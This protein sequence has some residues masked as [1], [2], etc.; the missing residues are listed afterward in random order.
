MILV[1]SG[2]YFVYDLLACIYYGLYDNALLAH[3]L[4]V[5][6]LAEFYINFFY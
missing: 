6:I 2:A 1:I 5:L 3:H 4:M